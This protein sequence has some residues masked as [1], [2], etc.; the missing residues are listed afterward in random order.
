[1]C[2]KE[3]DKLFLWPDEPLVRFKRSDDL[4]YQ[5]VCD[6]GCL[7]TLLEV[8][9]EVSVLGGAFALTTVGMERVCGWLNELMQSELGGFSVALF[10]KAEII[11]LRTK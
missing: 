2:S 9:L 10:A 8:R 1:V 4:R 5:E 6:F 3:L 7:V 11:M